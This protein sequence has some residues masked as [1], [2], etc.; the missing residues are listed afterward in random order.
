MRSVLVSTADLQKSW[1]VEV[2]GPWN[3]PELF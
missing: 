1:L 2:L 3:Q